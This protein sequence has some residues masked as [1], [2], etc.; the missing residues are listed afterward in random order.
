VL[1][2]VGIPETRRVS[3]EQASGEAAI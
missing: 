2:L 3:L 1:T